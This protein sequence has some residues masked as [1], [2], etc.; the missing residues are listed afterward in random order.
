MLVLYFWQGN[1]GICPSNVEP[2]TEKVNN[3][4]I[5]MSY[6][7]RSSN[8]EF[9]RIIA[10]SMIIIG[11]FLTH[12]IGRDALPHNIYYLLSPYCACGVNLFFL[13]SG[14]FQIRLSSRGLFQLIST[15]FLFGMINVLL[16]YLVAERGI[17][18]QEIFSF[19]FF[20]ISKSPYWF[21]KYISYW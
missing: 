3:S 16:V 7:E 21:F 8:I 13:V 10:M 19:I 5:L 6:T 11:H 18:S 17:T 1:E 20:P 9:L 12:A 2:S 15:L 14:Y 4:L